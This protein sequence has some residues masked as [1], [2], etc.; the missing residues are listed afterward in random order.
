[1]VVKQHITTK[2][3]QRSDHQNTFILNTQRKQRLGSQKYNMSFQVFRY[4]QHR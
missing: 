3:G 2:P 1:M 4:T